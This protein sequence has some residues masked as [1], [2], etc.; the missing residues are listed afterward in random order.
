MDMTADRMALELV[1]SRV[2]D[3][4]RELVWQAWTDP[5]HILGWWGPAGFGSQ[6]CEA[7]LRVGGRFLLEMRAPDGTVHPCRGI[8]REIVEHE[9][10]VYSSEADDRHPCGAG[11]PPR[12]LVTVSFTAQGRQTL[13]TIHTRFE[14]AACKEAAAEARFVVSWREGLERLAEYISVRG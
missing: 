7:E 5:R 4:P 2:F 1:I 13:L 11:L 6:S 10:L 8:Y 9:R 12:S 14:T 3:A